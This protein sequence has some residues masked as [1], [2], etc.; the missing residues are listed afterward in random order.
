MVIGLGICLLRNQLIL[1]VQG[2][3]YWG[4]MGGYSGIITGSMHMLGKSEVGGSE[5]ASSNEFK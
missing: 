5:T 4:G 1:H 3:C 2:K